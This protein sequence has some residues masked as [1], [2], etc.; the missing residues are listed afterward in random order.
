MSALLSHCLLWCGIFLCS[1]L[2]WIFS[3]LARK[4]WLILV[5]LWKRFFFFFEIL[6]LKLGIESLKFFFFVRK[7]VSLS[8]IISKKKIS[9]KSH[10]FFFFFW[11]RYHLFFETLKNFHS[12][13]MIFF[14]FFLK[15]KRNKIFFFLEV[16]WV[17]CWGLC[18]KIQFIGML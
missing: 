8:L 17:N 3:F 15:E 18:P 4:L 6:N 16:D 12:S 7:F 10:N 1:F 5:I 11:N 2:I 14:F 9:S 13:F